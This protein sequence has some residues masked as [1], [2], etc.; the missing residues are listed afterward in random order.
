MGDE[1]HTSD[2]RS[3]NDDATSSSSS[4][5]SEFSWGHLL[6]HPILRRCIPMYMALCAYNIV[7]SEILPLYGIA[8]Q[9][10]EGL[11]ISTTDIGFVFTAN[12]AISVVMNLLFPH[13]T[14]RCTTLFLWRACNLMFAATV[15]LN[16]VTTSLN[17]YHSRSLTMGWLIFL[18]FF[19]CTASTW[20]FSLSMMFVANAAPPEHLGKVTGMS[21]S[22]GSLMRSLW[23]LVAA[24]MFAWS[25][26]SH[27]WFPF[28]HYLVFAVSA[29]LALYAY[30][31]SLSL[32]EDDVMNPNKI[33]QNATSAATTP[34]TT[35]GTGSVS[36]DEA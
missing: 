7:Y 29:L 36:D 33:P 22:F 12:A 6:R 26:S 11:Q 5:R 13:V 21:H 1:S 20:C 18:A 34:R 19:R 2:H 35:I 27:H 8:L 3:R 32:T 25:I 30:Y 14:K 16:G 28:N 31:L 24:P 23:P 17:S 4:S 15:M 10:D 9:K